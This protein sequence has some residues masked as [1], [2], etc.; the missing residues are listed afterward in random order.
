MADSL[1][2]TN[3]R[4]AGG[5]QFVNQRL[6]RQPLRSVQEMRNRTVQGLRLGRAIG[7]SSPKTSTMLHCGNVLHEKQRSQCQALAA[8]VPRPNGPGFGWDRAL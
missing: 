7:C 8:P 3:N 5:S 1:A 6:R 4:R 2:T